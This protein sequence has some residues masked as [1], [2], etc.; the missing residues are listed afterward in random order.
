MQPFHCHLNSIEA[1]IQ[2]TYELESNDVLPF[3]DTEVMHHPV[4]GWHFIH[5][6]LRKK[7][8]TSKYLDFQPHRLLAHKLAVLRTLF[9]QAQRLCSNKVDRANEENTWNQPSLILATP[10]GSFTRTFPNHINFP[11]GMTENHW[12]LQFSSLTYIKSPN[13]SEGSWPH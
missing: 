6:G 10:E 4:P 3:L 11:D 1:L 13:Q 12:R 9:K 5:K 2:S 7:T 8:H